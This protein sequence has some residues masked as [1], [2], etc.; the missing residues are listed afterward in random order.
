MSQP[1]TLICTVGGSHEPIVKAIQAHRPGRVCFVCSKDDQ[2]TLQK[3]SWQQIEG[4]GLCI[5]A[6]FTDDKPTL[7]NIPA[8]AGLAQGSYEILRITPDDFDDIYA[9][10]SG[11]L[12]HRPAEEVL[13]ADYTGGTKTMSA[14]LVALALDDERIDLR[15]VTGNRADLI[16]VQSGSE[17]AVPA[18]IEAARLRRSL[19]D[20]LSLWKHH[21]YGESQAL[22]EQIRVPRDNGL[23]STLQFAQ[24]LSRAFSAWDRFDHAAANAILQNYRARLGASY[25]AHYNALG[26]LAEPG[27]AQEPARL[28]DLYRNAQRRAVGQRFDDAIARLYRLTEWSAQWLLRERAGIDTADV[29]AD[30]IPPGLELSKHRDGHFQAGLFAAWELAAHH[31]GDVVRQ[32]W[33]VEHTHLLD[34]LKVRNHSILAHGF[35][36]LERS[37]WLTFSGW[38]NEKLIPLLLAVT[39]DKQYRIAALPEQLPDK[40][41]EAS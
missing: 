6:R 22:L 20:A 27:P 41:P 38:V 30:K 9:S 29:P 37:H 33:D 36:P 14:A 3:G 21:G 32:F 16:K 28:F 7:P 25:V 2:A 24:D 31:G 1:I 10:V 12:A 18:C 23:R 19:S 5:K 11:W 15:L 39:A 13:I 34:Q 26:K 40:F 35:T 17:M 8:Q 4:K